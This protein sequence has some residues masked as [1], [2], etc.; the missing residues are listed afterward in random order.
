[1]EII[2]SGENCVADST[3]GTDCEVG[4]CRKTG[5]VAAQRQSRIRPGYALAEA[6][7]DGAGAVAPS[8][9]ALSVISRSTAL[10]TCSDFI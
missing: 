10:L 7:G 1:M 5:R 8:M 3:Q 6:L 2:G 9:A 4:A